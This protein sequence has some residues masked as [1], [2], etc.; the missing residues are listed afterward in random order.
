MATHRRQA[1]SKDGFFRPLKKARL[2]PER[3]EQNALLIAWLDDCVKAV[4]PLYDWA[5]QSRTWPR[6]VRRAA[7]AAG[8]DL[9]V[10]SDVS[11]PKGGVRMP[12]NL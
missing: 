2:S 4:E 1:Q 10:K 7:E 12:P 8:V 3:V 5:P 6:A 11:D 9:T